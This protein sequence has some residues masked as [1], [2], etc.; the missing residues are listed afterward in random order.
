MVQSFLQNFVHYFA[1]RGFLLILLGAL[2]ISKP[3]GGQQPALNLTPRPSSVQAG[4]GSLRLDSSF[5]AALTGYSEPRLDRRVERLLERLARQTAISLTS[6]VA[7][8]AQPALLT[9]TSHACKEIMQG[10]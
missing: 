9:R 2:L 3:A 1:L 8:S 5:S 10:G 7:K 6:K 4:T